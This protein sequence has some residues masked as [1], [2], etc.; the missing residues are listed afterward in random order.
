MIRF[1]KVRSAH[2]SEDADCV[3]LVLTFEEFY[4]TVLR[5]NLPIEQI[6]GISHC[7]QT[8]FRGVTLQL[9]TFDRSQINLLKEY[10]DRNITGQ[11]N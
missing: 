6:G 11:D 8:E 5:L 1:Y 7:W 9:T 3:V 10:H 4:Q 2:I